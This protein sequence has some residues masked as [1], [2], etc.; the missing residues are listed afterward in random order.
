MNK[1]V[2]LK[3][4]VWNGAGYIGP[5]G[6]NTSSGYAGEHGYGHEEWNGRS[7][8]VWK[9]WKVFHT[10]GKGQMFDYAE[11]GDLGI[12]MTT[13]RDGRF[14]AV[15]VGCA[16]YA[17]S[18]KDRTA[19]A[20]DLRLRDNGIEL[21]KL[22]KVRDLKRDK[23]AFDAHWEDAYASVQWRCPQSHFAWFNPPI[24]ISPNDIIPAVPPR[25][26]RQ[27]IIMMHSSYQA[28]RPDQ[29]LAIIGNKL[30]SSH[31]VLA[32]LSTGD[33]DEVST[34]GVG[35]APPP[36]SKAG[37]S[38]GTPTDPYTR[39]LQ[40][41]EFQVTPKHHNLQSAFDAYLRVSKAKRIVP[42]MERVDVRYDD[43]QKGPVLAEI[44]PSDPQ[45]V[46]FA[47][48][49]A[50]GQLLDYRQNDAGNPELLIVVGCKPSSPKDLHL[51]LDNGFG[52][53]WKDGESFAIRWPP[54]QSRAVGDV[55]V[56]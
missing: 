22:P 52:L 54:A 23:A 5:T 9:G 26:P 38:S 43:A 1:M 40:E 34:P 31:P 2:V 29:A 25:P 45:T 12:V 10:Q 3:P 50:I 49:A 19:I 36:R 8:W 32:W 51:A 48:R 47:I 44:K 27:A 21:W 39:Y 55:S 7:D 46:R 56:A 53:A 20:K 30:P 15:G 16:V 35:D 4:V 28:V 41:N 42:N 33:F 17:N 24:P 13:M 18:D 6:D 11:D 14:Y 37:R